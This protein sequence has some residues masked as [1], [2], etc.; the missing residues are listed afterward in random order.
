MGAP[1]APVD[2]QAWQLVDTECYAYTV[3]APDRTP[4]DV[5]HNA[6]L[7]DYWTLASDASRATAAAV[8][9]VK[10]SSVGFLDP[11]SSGAMVESYAHVL[12]LEW[13]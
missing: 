4:L 1:T 7:G 10:V 3:G 9:Y 8:G 11:P 6:A 5:W 12:R 2:G 13:S